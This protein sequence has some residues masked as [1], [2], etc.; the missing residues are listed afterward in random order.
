MKRVYVYAYTEMNL[1]DDLF[2]K[3]LCERYPDVKFYIMAKVKNSKPFDNIKNLVVIPKIPWID[4]LLTKFKVKKSI[5]GLI[6][7]KISF[8]CDAIVCIGGSLFKTHQFKNRIVHDKPFFVL[9]SN[10]GPYTDDGF[11]QS[12]KS[13]FS[14]LDDICFR[15]EYSYRLFS[16]LINVRKEADVVFSYKAKYKIKEL[17]KV[18]ISVINL[19]SRPELAK[20]QKEYIEKIVEI[21]KKFLDNNYAVTL[22]GFC[23]AEGDS[24][25]INK[26]MENMI[27]KNN[28][29]IEKYI[30]KGNINEALDI[31]QESKIIVG[32]R[33]HAMIL[34]WL[35]YK[36]V[37]PIIYSE[38]SL[39]VMN[40]IGFNGP[41][42][43]IKDIEQLDFESDYKK[44]LETP[45]I[46]INKEINSAN[47]QFKKLDELLLNS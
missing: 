45:T 19:N 22:M 24:E 37:Y 38:K 21:A 23:T 1:G 35:F 9:G 20:Y 29:C 14:S 27:L 5:N 10:F 44:L 11:I 2:I 30:Y 32:S 40:D 8:F 13:I 41:Y 3:V 43:N 34:G 33:F 36:K 25:I 31:I 12:F 46:M 4:G 47:Q 15:D 42:I 28:K 7:R 17:D 26:I 16:D 18:T 39:N 6:Q